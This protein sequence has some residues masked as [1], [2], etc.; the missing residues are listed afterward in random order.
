MNNYYKVRLTVEAANEEILEQVDRDVIS[1]L[2]VL[3]N[4]D[5]S[6]AVNAMSKIEQFLASCPG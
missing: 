3:E 5:K 1:G 4:F 2:P 6:P